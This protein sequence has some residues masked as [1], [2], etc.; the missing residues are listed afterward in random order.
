MAGPRHTNLFKYRWIEASTQA[1]NWRFTPDRNPAALPKLLQFGWLSRR[2]GVQNRFAED[3]QTGNSVSAG[4][5]T[6]KHGV[7][8]L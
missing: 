4:L 5:A 8:K 3:A 6:A 7:A 1:P 2:Y